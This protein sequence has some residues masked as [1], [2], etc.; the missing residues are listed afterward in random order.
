M[1]DKQLEDLEIFLSRFSVKRAFYLGQT[2]K[3]YFDHVSALHHYASS[4]FLQEGQHFGAFFSEDAWPFP[5]K[6]FDLV[7]LDNGLV[8]NSGLAQIIMEAVRVLSDEGCLIVTQHKKSLLSDTPFRLV[9]KAIKVQGLHKIESHYYDIFKVQTT[10]SWLPCLL[11]ESFSYEYIASFS[12]QVIPLS[13]LFSGA[14]EMVKL[15][16]K[17]AIGM[18]KAFKTNINHTKSEKI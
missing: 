14:K 1:Q 15:P 17:Y 12:K 4:G 10:Q 2:R 18:N 5:S 3:A 9:N 8:N 6:L 16:G 11:P 13:P 7:I